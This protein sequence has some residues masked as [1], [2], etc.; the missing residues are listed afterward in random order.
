VTQGLEAPRVALAAILAATSV[1]IGLLAG[2]DPVFAIGAAIGLAFVLVA[3]TNLAL[4]LSAFIMVGFFEF[5]LP[6]GSVVSVSKLAGLVLAASVLARLATSSDPRESFFAAHP[7][8]TLLL[9]AFLGWGT[10]SI[11]W[12][13]TSSGTLVDLSRYLLNF[14]LLIVVYTAVRER[15]HIK[16][17]I[18]VWVAGTALTAMYGLA[19]HP[20][21]GAEAERASSS[22]GNANV[23]ATVLV[24]GLVLALAGAMATRSPLLRIAGLGVAGLSMLG[25][26][27]TGSRSGVLALG[28]VL[29]AACIIGGRWRGRVI[30]GA[31]LLAVAAL[32]TFVA[33]AP[34]DIKQRVTETTPG[35]VPDTEGRLTLW[36]VAERMVKDRPVEGVGLGSFQASAPNYLLQPGVLTRTDQIID[37]PKVVHNIYLQ[38]LAEEGIIGL[39]LFLLVL[40]FLLGCGLKAAHRFERVGDTQMEILARALVVALVGVLV[41]DFFASEQFSK[42][43]WLLLGLGPAMLAVAQASGERAKEDERPAPPVPYGVS[44]P[45]LPGPA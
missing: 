26:V 9:L 24:A 35:Q 28:A 15:R 42:L 8:G 23:Y 40:G 36:Q 43:L 45:V 6:A 17:V 33:F 2:F 38:A 30:A 25:F 21:V 3:I 44:R 11:A 22:V 29:L 4:G 27:F 32:M 19:T 20:A 18:G 34:T 41:A 10:L 31:L 39:V 16:W 12:S 7:Q 37:T 5:T 14:A 1:F 13:D